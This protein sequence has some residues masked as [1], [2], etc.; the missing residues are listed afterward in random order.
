MKEA[1]D[2]YFSGEL[3]AQEKALLLDKIESDKD[4]RKEFIRMQNTVALSRLYPQKNDSAWAGKMFGELDK[5]IQQK[6]QRRILWNITRYAAVIAL[7]IVNGWLLTRIVSPVEEEEIAYTIIEVPKGQRVAL[8]L[9]D[10]TKAWFSPRS[11]V[12]I[13][14]QFRKN[15]RTIELDGEG[16]FDVSQDKERPFVVKTKR[17]DIK[18]LGTRFNVFAYSE[19][20]RFETDLLSGKVEVSDR[21]NP[22]ETAVLQPGERVTLVGNR[23]ALSSSDFN[24][25]DYLKNGIFHFKNESF[26]SILEYLTL[27]YEVRFDIKDSAKKELPVS[28]KFRQSDDI[29]LILKGLQG[30]HTFNYKLINEQLIEI[31]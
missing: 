30:V 5:K 7:L 11:V 1:L 3:S 24:N 22:V 10:G 25:E 31:Y 6:K 9:A 28:G 19:S 20:P 26:E 8:T 27:W 18:V 12:K 4:Y 17:H 15:E 13:P 14:N 23:L 29:K 16:Y 21:M 2:K